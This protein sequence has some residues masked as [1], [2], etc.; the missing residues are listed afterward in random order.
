M[1]KNQPLKIRDGLLSATIWTNT[2]KEGNTYYTVTLE[3]SFKDGDDEWQN[4]NS[5]NRSDL[6]AAAR[7]LQK[8]YDQIEEERKSD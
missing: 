3:R 5:L 2:S 7:L 8:A 4:T 1:G 6:L